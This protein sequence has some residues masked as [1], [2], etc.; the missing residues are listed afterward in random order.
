MM[1]SHSIP[2]R[3]LATHILLSTL[4][5]AI[6]QLLLYFAG[7]CLKDGI[8][9]LSWSATHMCGLAIHVLLAIR[10]PHKAFFP[11][12]IYSIAASS[13]IATHHNITTLL[14]RYVGD[15][16]SGFTTRQHIA[17][18]FCLVF[19]A[20]TELRFYRAYIKFK[21]FDTYTDCL[22]NLPLA[23]VNPALVYRYEPFCY[24]TDLPDSW[25][26]CLD[27]DNNPRTFWE[28]AFSKSHNVFYV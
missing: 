23:N 6:P 13:L 16:H 28:I 24:M 4:A 11:D 26:R 21:R 17:V 9:S 14:G 20:I 12:G 22:D 25:R 1:P 3:R 8:V 15:I 18:L 7:T 5:A 27:V 10:D 19:Y 2:L